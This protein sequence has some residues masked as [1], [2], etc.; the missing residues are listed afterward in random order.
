MKLIVESYLYDKLGEEGVV[1]CKTCN[2]RCKIK[3]DKWGKCRVRKNDNGKLNVYNY[4]M[5]SSIAVD[6]IEKKPL[7]NFKPGSD[8]LS[9]GTVS[10]NFRCLHCQNYEIAFSDLNF[11]YLKEM[12]TKDI[13]KMVNE[14]NVQGV[15]WTYN[16]PAIW[17][18]F[19]LDSSKLVK[20]NN[21]N[22][23]VIYVTNGYVTKESVDQH[24]L[25]AANIDIK[26]FNERFYK[27]ICKAS[28]DKVLESTEYMYKKGIHIEITNLVIPGENDS[29]K[30]LKDFSDWV[31]S[32]GKEI[33]VHFS[34][35]HPDHQMMDKPATPIE[36]LERAAKIAMKTGLEYVYLGNIWGHKLENTFC[37]NCEFKIIERDGYLTKVN[38]IDKK[39]PECGYEQNIIL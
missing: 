3:P 30:D 21:K 14:K 24:V 20:K 23:Y 32:L 6:P 8:V 31:Y 13:V 7:Y 34:R 25:D 19:T 1:K 2:H 4:G 37:P 39:C 11:P 18:E 29:N 5:V 28:L 22:L 35:F 26:G 38:I 9:F 17:H 16:E 10:C 27:K 12:T 15:A 36:T 33:P